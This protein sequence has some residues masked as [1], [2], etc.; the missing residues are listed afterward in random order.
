M[1]MGKNAGVKASIGVLTGVDGTKEL[2]KFADV[3]IDSVALLDVVWSRSLRARE[4]MLMTSGSSAREQGCEID[5]SSLLHLEA[6]KGRNGIQV[7][8]GGK[9]VMVA[10]AMGA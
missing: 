2:G 3:V 6:G 7:H 4:L 8:V 10:R 5:R 1:K 9:V